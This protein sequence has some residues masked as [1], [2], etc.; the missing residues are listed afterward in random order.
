MLLSSNWGVGGALDGTGESPEPWL[1][2]VTMAR[3]FLGGGAQDRRLHEGIAF[4]A[5]Q[6]PLLVLVDPVEHS[7]T[8][9]PPQEFLSQARITSSA[10]AGRHRLQG[11]ACNPSTPG[12]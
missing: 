10:R 3:Q 1:P 4:D 11:Q 7:L 9:W 2:S 5:E 8:G 12:R 6:H